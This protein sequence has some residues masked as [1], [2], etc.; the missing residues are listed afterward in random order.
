MVLNGQIFSIDASFAFIV[1]II[2]TVFF[3]SIAS[4][5]NKETANKYLEFMKEKRLVDAS[6]KLVSITLAEY[7]QDTLK[8]HEL[9]LEKISLLSTTDILEIKKVLL[10]EDYNISLKIDAGN[11]SLL[12]IG[13]A[14][15]SV[16]KRIALC[17]EEIC[18][19]KISAK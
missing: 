6:E 4:Y 11:S 10:L 7:S 14:G 18:I 1:L 15:G 12:D 5:L 8:H 13:D 2:C 3:L 19:V 17:G 9:S 16:V